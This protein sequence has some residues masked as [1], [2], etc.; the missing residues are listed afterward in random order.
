MEIIQNF[1]Y[2]KKKNPQLTYPKSQKQNLNKSKIKK[3]LELLDT[4]TNK[5]YYT[6][7]S[8]SIAY[9]YSQYGGKKFKGK[10][11]LLGR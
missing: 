6:R 4:N 10:R 5:Y 9:S 11:R 7:T 3:N 2:I 1:F 8:L